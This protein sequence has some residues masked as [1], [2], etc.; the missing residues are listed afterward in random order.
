M[1]LVEKR[2]LVAVSSSKNSKS[3]FLNLN[4]F[5]PFLESQKSC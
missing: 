4:F 2:A 1:D 3:A 5:H